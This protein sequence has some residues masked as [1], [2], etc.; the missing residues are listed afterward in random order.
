MVIHGVRPTTTRLVAMPVTAHDELGVVVVCIHRQ[1]TDDGVSQTLVEEPKELE[2]DKEGEEDVNSSA[3]VKRAIAGLRLIIE[4]CSY[5]QI[6]DEGLTVIP[7]RGGYRT[8]TT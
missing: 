8:R 3:P 1:L 7:N 2:D 5:V 6:P 4:V